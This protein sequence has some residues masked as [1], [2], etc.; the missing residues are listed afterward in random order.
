MNLS[1]DACVGQ[2]LV[3]KDTVNAYNAIGGTKIVSTFQTGAT[4]GT[5]YA[6]ITDPVGN[7]WWSIDSDTPIYVQHDSNKLSLP[8]IDEANKQGV[9]INPL[10]SLGVDEQITKYNDNKEDNSHWYDGILKGL[11]NIG[12]TAEIAVIIFIIVL[13]IVGINKVFP[14]KQLLPKK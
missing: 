14:L 13:L 4:I 5:I 9:P 11:G 6:W 10:S 1:A 3:A 7:L 12:S 8:I 2:V